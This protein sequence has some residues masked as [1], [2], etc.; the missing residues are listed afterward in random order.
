M[1]AGIVLIIDDEEKLRALLA[2][3][4]RLEG[5]VV[6]EAENLKAAGRFV[7]IALEKRNDRYLQ[8]IPRSLG[9]V[10]RNLEHY[11][12]LH[13]LRKALTRYVPEL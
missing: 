7:Y 12:D 2:R 3:I 10:R 11:R 5:Y 13:P 8:Y 9:Y 6:L 1:S 4:I